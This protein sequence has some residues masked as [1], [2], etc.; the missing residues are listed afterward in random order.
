MLLLKPF[1]SYLLSILESYCSLTSLQCQQARKEI[2]FQQEIRTCSVSHL[3]DVT[4]RSMD[5]PALHTAVTVE[6]RVIWTAD[7]RLVPD[8]DDGAAS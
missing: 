2:G 6:L 5:D 3:D 1:F 7:L 8:E 4:P